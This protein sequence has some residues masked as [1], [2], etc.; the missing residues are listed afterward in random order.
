MNVHVPKDSDNHENKCIEELLQRL[1]K[2]TQPD[3]I[4]NNIIATDI[5]T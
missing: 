3:D 1:E 2:T 4:S 5:D